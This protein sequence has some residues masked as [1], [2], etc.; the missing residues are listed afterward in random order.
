MYGGIEAGG[1]KFVC[2]VGTGPDD[3]SEMIRFPTTTPQETI[4][5]AIDFFRNQPHKLS[6]IGIASFGPVDPNP[7][8]NTFGFITSTPKPGWKNTDL[9]GEVGRAL[10]VPIGFD[11][12]VNG[13]VLAEAK[14][15]AAKGLDTCLYLTIGTGVGGGAIVRGQPLHGLLHP[16]MGHI[17]VPRAEG[18]TFEGI[19]PYHNDCLEGMATGAGLEKLGGGVP[20]ETLPEDHQAWEFEA[21]YLAMAVVNYTLI[22]SPQRV[23]MGG[24]VMDQRHL[25]P[26]I[27]KKGTK[28]FKWLCR[29]PFNY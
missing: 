5:L 9:A 19:C 6:G 18:D 11:T 22:L 15:G 10:N 27:R 28:C 29:R 13:A 25:F 7:T 16:E 26:R 4:G 21:H 8:S 14:W 23:I 17:R 20:A 3:L 1:T 2:A 24:G 12:D